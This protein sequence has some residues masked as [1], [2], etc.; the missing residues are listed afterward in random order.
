M[1]LVDGESILQKLL[2]L[3]EVNT[4]GT[5]G[6]R[7]RWRAA[8]VYDV[9]AVVVLGGVE[10]GLETGLGVRPGTGVQGLFLAP[11]N[12]L[13]VGVAVQVVPQLG[14]GEGVQ[15]LDTGDGGVANAVGLTVLDQSGVHLARA[16][17]HTL[18]LL[19]LVDGG[20]VGRVGDDPLEVGVLAEGLDVGA[21]DR[22]T[23]QRLGEEDHKG[24]NQV[25][26]LALWPRNAKRGM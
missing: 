3:L 24:W 12:V 11:H 2:L 6:D 5:S 19:G 10:Q 9:A 26:A 16:H 8:G 18:D 1:V 20:A 22:V 7:G 23:Q 15:L 4:L 25:L 21:G 14:P 13:S 17:D